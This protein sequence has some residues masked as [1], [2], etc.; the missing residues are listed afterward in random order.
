MSTRCGAS[1]R[2]KKK[3]NK[4]A[5]WRGGGKKEKKNEKSWAPIKQGGI[6]NPLATIKRISGFFCYYR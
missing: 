4:K 3:G 1:I 2:S 6:R 5:E